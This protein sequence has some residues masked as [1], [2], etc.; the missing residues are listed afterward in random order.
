MEQKI[1]WETSHVLKKKKK[2]GKHFIGNFNKIK[3][4]HQFLSLICDLVRIKGKKKTPL[5]L[6][7]F[8]RF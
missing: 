4:Y 2:K 8:F 6:L 1:I 5:L 3:L 7:V